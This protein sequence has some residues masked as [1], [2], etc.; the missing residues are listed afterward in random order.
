M[1]NAD[2]YEPRFTP[3]QADPPAGV[4]GDG[5]G[6]ND[7]PAAPVSSRR[8]SLETEKRATV[9]HSNGRVKQARDRAQYVRQQKGHS[10]VLEVLVLG[11][12]TLWVRPIY[13]AVSPNHYFHL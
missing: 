6:P 2:Y 9:S 10:F 12:F 3:P 1:T 7:W 8:A 13:L 4:H 5:F 11:I